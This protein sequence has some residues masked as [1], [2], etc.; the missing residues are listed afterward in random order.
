MNKLCNLIASAASSFPYYNPNFAKQM[1]IRK[2]VTGWRSLNSGLDSGLS[3][4]KLS[5]MLNLR[6]IFAWK[7]ILIIA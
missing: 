2:E 1:K 7:I 4:S 5:F 3:V 6:L